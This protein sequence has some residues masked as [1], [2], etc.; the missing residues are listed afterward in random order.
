MHHTNIKIQILMI[1]KFF[2][3]ATVLLQISIARVAQSVEHWSNKPTV[4][5]SIPVVSKFIFCCKSFYSTGKSLKKKH[6]FM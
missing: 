3:Y 6:L 2:K 4:A 5:G 1:L